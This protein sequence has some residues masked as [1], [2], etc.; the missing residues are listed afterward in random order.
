MIESVLSLRC[1]IVAFDARIR[2]EL[3]Q[4]ARLC[5]IDSRLALPLLTSERDAAEPETDVEINLRIP[6]Q[7]ALANDAI[8]KLACRIACFCPHIRVTTL[9]ES[10]A[11]I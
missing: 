4:I 3:V 8:W 7:L 10:P 9:I 6:A 11:Q 2:S 1:E 5:A